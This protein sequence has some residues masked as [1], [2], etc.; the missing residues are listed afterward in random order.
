MTYTSNLLQTHISMFQSIYVS[1]IS[2]HIVL[3]S[4][5]TVFYSNYKIYIVQKKKKG[6]SSQKLFVTL[7]ILFYFFLYM[8]IVVA[9]FL[10]YELMFISL[11]FCT[12]VDRNIQEN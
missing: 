10:T 11:L 2:T 6:T 8:Y 3:V 7:F 1:L 9:F 4:I 5:Q 12:F